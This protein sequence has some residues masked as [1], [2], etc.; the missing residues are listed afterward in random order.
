MRAVLDIGGDGRR[1]DDSDLEVHVSARSFCIGRLVGAEF[2]EAV[3][4]VE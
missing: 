1:S 2:A 4:D 3:G